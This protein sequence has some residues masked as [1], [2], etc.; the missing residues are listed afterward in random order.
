MAALVRRQDHTIM[1]TTTLLLALIA[2]AI[3]AG[4]STTSSHHDFTGI[5]AADFTVAVTCG[6]P[7]TRFSGTIVSDGKTEHLSGTGRSTFQVSG[8]EIVCAFK[9]VDAVGRIHMKITKA[10]GLVGEATNDEKFGGVRAELLYA[11]DQ[12]Y[13]LFTSF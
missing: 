5:P 3:F 6:E 11:P 9:K 13:T 12:R 10:G 2:A 1:R 4:C 7:S 8:H